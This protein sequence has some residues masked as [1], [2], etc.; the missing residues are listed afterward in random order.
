[1]VVNKHQ[2]KPVGS[3]DI[4]GTFIRD[5][6]FIYLTKALC[7]LGIFPVNA[8]AEKHIVSISKSRWENRL[9]SYDVYIQA[10]ADFFFENIGGVE[11][12]VVQ[13]IANNILKERYRHV[14][15]FTRE[16]FQISKESYCTVAVTGSQFEMVS[17]FQK[18][19]PFDLILSTELETQHGNYT[20]K[21]AARPLSNK[22]AALQDVVA[23]N[24]LVFDKSFHVGDS[25]G[26]ISVMRRVETPICYNPNDLLYLEAA[27]N[28]WIVVIERKNLIM[29][30]QDHK[31]S[32]VFLRTHNKRALRNYIRQLLG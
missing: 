19:W 31:A 1:M 30:L 28:N 18:Y 17:A 32:P 22:I 5:S 16:L 6:L 7:D 14:N 10:V 25:E 11:Q 13:E 29:I 12:H 2:G 24:G 26:D 15:V 27:E 20:G 4:D 23:L 8:F 9:E 3:F 21:V